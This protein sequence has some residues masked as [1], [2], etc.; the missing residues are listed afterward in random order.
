[1]P[2]IVQYIRCACR[3]LHQSTTD[4]VKHF[5]VKHTQSYVATEPFTCD[6][7]HQTYDNIKLGFAHF[8]DDHSFH[9]YSCE[10][11]PLSWFTHT[12]AAEHITCNCPICDKRVCVCE[13]Y[14]AHVREYY[15]LQAAFH[16]PHQ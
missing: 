2:R 11:C 3:Y 1:M 6:L 16:N 8:L 4:F 7:C 10:D 9:E 15:E 5:I 14:L 12:E 13:D